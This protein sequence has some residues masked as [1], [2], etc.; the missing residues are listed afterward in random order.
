MIEIRK[1]DLKDINTIIALGKTTFIESH[2]GFIQ[3]D[4]AVQQF[5]E[6]AFHPD[7]ISEDLSDTNTIF[8][9][10]F[11]NNVPVGF[12][13]VN[14]NISNTY[15]KEEKVCKLDKIYILNAYIGKQLGKKLHKEVIATITDLQYDCIWLVTYIHNYKAITFYEANHYKKIGYFDYMI[16]GKG[17]KNHILVKNLKE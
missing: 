17:Y 10:L 4:S 12:A 2:S 5:C 15:I 1:A 16:A 3:N 14:L 13:K 9:L 6:S 7:K 8:W 11:Y